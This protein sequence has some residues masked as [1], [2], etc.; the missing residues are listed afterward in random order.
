MINVKSI[1]MVAGGTEL[2]VE[3]DKEIITAKTY[4]DFDGTDK[5]LIKGELYEYRGGFNIVKVR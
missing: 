1:K 5:V 4:F 3:I 2:T